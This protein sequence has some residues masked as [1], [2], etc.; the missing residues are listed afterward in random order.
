[1]RDEG[2]TLMRAKDVNSPEESCDDIRTQLVRIYIRRKR[3]KGIELEVDDLTI[4]FPISE[5][6][7]TE[8]LSEIPDEWKT[9]FEPPT[10]CKW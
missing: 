6:Q 4:R 1:M 5:A 10:P 3:R 7:A 8:L 2:D 9:L